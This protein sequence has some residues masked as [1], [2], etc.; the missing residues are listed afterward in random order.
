MFNLGPQEVFWV[1]LVFCILLVPGILYTQA[2]Y[3]ALSRCSPESRTMEPWTVWLLYVP[4][5]N[6]IWHFVV[7]VRLSASL[8]NEFRRRGVA[9]PIDTGRGLGLAMNVLQCVAWVPVLGALCILAGMI[10]WILYWRK[11]ADLSARIAPAPLAAPVTAG[12]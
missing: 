2:L 6:I 7:V 8:R 1:L 12:S 11:V 5:F 10:C 4:V 9:E 3:R